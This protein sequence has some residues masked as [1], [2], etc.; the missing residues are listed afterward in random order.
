MHI[1]PLYIYGLW[2]QEKVSEPFGRDV[3]YH[4]RNSPHNR[5]PSLPRHTRSFLLQQ[6]KS[7][8]VPT[9][10]E[11]EDREGFQGGRSKKLDASFV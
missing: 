3:W 8:K 10:R 4:R 1:V 5:F 2:I 11:K 9:R 6:L 7:H